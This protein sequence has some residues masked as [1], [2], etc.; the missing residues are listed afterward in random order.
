MLFD[1]TLGNAMLS[2]VS[3]AIDA[4]SAQLIGKK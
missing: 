3:A 2:L 1:A 4:C